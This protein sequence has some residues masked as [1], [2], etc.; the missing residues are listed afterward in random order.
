MPKRKT[1]ED[2][3]RLLLGKSFS[4]VDKAMDWPARLMGRYHR[5]VLH[6]IPEGFIIGLLLTGNARGALAGA[7][8]VITDTVDSGAKKEIKKLTKNRG[9]G[10]CLKKRKRKT[11]KRNKHRCS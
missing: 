8:H 1:H 11:E 6:T 3:S 10:N 7:L 5:R 4:N 9:D 2:I